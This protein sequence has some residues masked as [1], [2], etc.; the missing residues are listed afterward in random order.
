[1]YSLVAR[2]TFMVLCSY[3]RRLILERFYHQ[4]ET[5]YPFPPSTSPH[6]PPTWPPLP[7]FLSLWIY[8]SWTLCI[9]GWIQN[10]WPFASSFS[11]LASCFRGSSRQCLGTAFSAGQP[12]ISRL[13]GSQTL[14]S[15]FRIS[16]KR[17]QAWP[18][19]TSRELPCW[20]RPSKVTPTAYVSVWSSSST[21]MFQGTF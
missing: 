19:K 17:H 6:C 1:M 7:G 9:N 12:A 2:N 10:M 13:P 5:R 11:H 16:G 8:L 21:G 20:Y 14:A 18:P 15:E 3:H 4:K